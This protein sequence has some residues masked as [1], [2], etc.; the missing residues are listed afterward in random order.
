ML[1]DFDAY[2][3]AQDKISRYYVNQDKWLSMSL[4]NIACSGIFSSD[5]TI[6]EYASGIWSVDRVMK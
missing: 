6:Q 4:M 1:K 5:R 2:V 3:A